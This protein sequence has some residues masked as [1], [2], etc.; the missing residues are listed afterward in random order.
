MERDGVTGRKCTQIETERRP[1][2]A[3]NTIFLCTR[4]LPN[5][6]CQSLSPGINGAAMLPQANRSARNNGN[7]VSLNWPDRSKWNLAVRVSCTKLG[8]LLKEICSRVQLEKLV[9]KV[10]EIREYFA[11]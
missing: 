3:G 11:V 8:K 1:L 9:H 7:R 5:R 10:I 2:V 4:F 6:I